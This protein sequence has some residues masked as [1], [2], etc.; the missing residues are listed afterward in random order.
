MTFDLSLARKV[1][2]SLPNSMKSPYHNPDYVS[3]DAEEKQKNENCSVKAAFFIYQKGGE[4][5][6]HPLHCT[7]TSH[8]DVTDFESARGY[9]GPISTTRDLQFL[10]EASV[11][12][13]KCLNEHN[14]L[15]EFIRFTP[16]LA[17]QEIYYGNYWFDRATCAIDLVGYGLEKNS[18]GAISNINKATKNNCRVSFTSS[19]TREQCLAFNRIY[20]ARMQALGAGEHYFYSEKYVEKL[21]AQGSLLAL[22][23]RDGEIVAAS[24]FLRTECWHEYH[25]S[26]ATPEGQKI[27][28]INLILHNYSMSCAMQ[29]SD[30]SAILHLGGG[31]DNRPDNNL[32]KFKRSVGKL[33]QSFC[34]GKYI[35]QPD[36]YE[37]LKLTE[38]ASNNRVLFY[39]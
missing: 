13:K 10:S 31:T 39:R 25:L 23:E 9:G 16:V 14:V 3:L 11:E 1:Y 33:E 20:N 21:I 18:H 36:R 26:A 4:T 12:Y 24:I 5:Y 30:G 2:Q 17:N 37:K 34:L 28:A 8:I 15:A 32:L 19:P 35:H 6:Y 7:Y 27:G 38:A 22:V 29:N